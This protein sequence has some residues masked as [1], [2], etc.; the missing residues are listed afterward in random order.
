VGIYILLSIFYVNILLI[1]CFIRA[2]ILF[3]SEKPIIF[4]TLDFLPKIYD[5]KSG[6]VSLLILR[7]SRF[8]VMLM[9]S[10]V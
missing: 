7:I 3:A 9:R 4:I 6:R 10:T 5:Q 1:A 2:S 8:F